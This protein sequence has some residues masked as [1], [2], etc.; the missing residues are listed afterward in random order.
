[1][2]GPVTPSHA[3]F[4]ILLV[5]ATEV[6]SGSNLRKEGGFC[7]CS[8]LE[9]IVHTDVV[10]RGCGSWLAVLPLLP[11]SRERAGSSFLG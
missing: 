8:Q 5:A 7:L 4:F 10:A 9:G 2:T 11:G 1:M 3:V 6:P